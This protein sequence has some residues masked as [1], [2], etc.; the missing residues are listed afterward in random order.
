MTQELMVR[1]LKLIIEWIKKHS[2]Q[3]QNIE[4]N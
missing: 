2:A 4:W 1:Y 3:L